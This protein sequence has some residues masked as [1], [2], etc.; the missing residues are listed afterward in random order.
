MCKLFIHCYVD[1]YIIVLTQQQQCEERGNLL[2]CDE[3]RNGM[4]V[5]V[6]SAVAAAA[7]AD[8][9]FRST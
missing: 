2:M 9:I 7:A 6:F 1:K 5:G 4:A 3:C 8:I